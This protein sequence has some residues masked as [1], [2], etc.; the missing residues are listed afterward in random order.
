MVPNSF[1]DIDTV[2][3]IKQLSKNDDQK[4][5]QANE[6]RTFEQEPSL[7]EPRGLTLHNHKQRIA[8]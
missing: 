6:V 7:F 4:W 3:C 1:R 5:P 8:Y 2:S